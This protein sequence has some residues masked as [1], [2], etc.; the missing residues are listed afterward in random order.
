[1][2]N[3][4]NSLISQI[5]QNSNLNPSNIT[6][7]NQAIQAIAGQTSNPQYQT[8][9][10]QMTDIVSTY[11]QIL[12]PG[13]ST[14]TSRAT[15][16]GLVN[17]LAQGSTVQQV[18]SSLDQQSQEKISGIQTNVGNIKSGSNVN[19]NNSLVGNTTTG[20]DGNQ[21]LITD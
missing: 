8:L 4:S 16:A 9:L 10:N 11:G 1:V 18:I 13:S 21:Y 6:A 12:T 7:V 19:P 2:A 14:D 20:P 15:A 17:Q 3:I 5:A